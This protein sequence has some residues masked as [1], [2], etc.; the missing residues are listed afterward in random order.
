MHAL[1]LSEIVRPIST[2]LFLAHHFG[3][4]MLHVSGPAERF[5]ALRGDLG[6]SASGDR[7]DETHGAIRLLAGRLERTLEADIQVHLAAVESPR[8]RLER[9][10]LLLALEGGTPWWVEDSAGEPAWRGT[11][12]A[13]DALYLP[14]DW[15]C[16]GENPVGRTL[17]VTIENPTGNDLVA[18]LTNML[19][20]HRALRL[21]IPRFGGPGEQADF[22][23][24]VRR[25]LMRALRSPGIVE[26]YRTYCHGAATRVS[27]PGVPWSEHLSAAHSIELGGTRRLIVRPDPQSVSITW[28][29]EQMAFPREAAQMLQFLSDETPV[30]IGRFYETF[31]QEFERDEL[32]DFLSVLSAKGVVVLREPDDDAN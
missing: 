29:G 13:G 3:K 18:W 11:L 16:A 15:W 30:T 21:D 25:P 5:A 6:A 32:A 2:D 12:A 4:K 20:D 19:K 31:E 22:M 23:A 7:L 10:L 28:R 24:A 1:D 14:R 8:R 27:R 26:R 9:D 17:C